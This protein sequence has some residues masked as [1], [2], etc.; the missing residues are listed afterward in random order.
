MIRGPERSLRAD[1]RGVAL[2]EALVALAILGI[3]IVGMV[4]ASSAALRGQANARAHREAAIVADAQ[5][6][7]MASA[8]AYALDNNAGE[9]HG[10]V[11]IGAREYRWAS[12]ARAAND[13]SGIWNLGVAVAWDDGRITLGTAVWRPPRKLPGSAVQ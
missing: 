10:V 13:S 9:R 6:S 3:A 12:R 7:A 4:E 11:T 1:E 8:S 2:L 5:L